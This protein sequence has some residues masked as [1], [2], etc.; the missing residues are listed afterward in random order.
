MNYHDQKIQLALA[1]DMRKH[2]TAALTLLGLIGNRF[3]DLPH[4]RLNQWPQNAEP[5]LYHWAINP[6]RIQVMPNLLFMVIALPINLNVSSKLH[7]YSL[8]RTWS[9]LEPRLPKRIG[10]THSCNYYNLKGKNIHCRW[11]LIRLKQLSSIS[12]CRGNSI[13]NIIPLLKKENVHQ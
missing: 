11:D 10:N 12:V 2:W 13:H 9:P 4:W 8:Q 3:C 1:H 7:P 6:H 5:K